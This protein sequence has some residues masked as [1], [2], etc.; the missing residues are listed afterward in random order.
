M[1]KKQFWVILIS[2]GLVLVLFIGVGLWILS[3]KKQTTNSLA[4]VQNTLAPTTTTE[5][6]STVQTPTSTETSQPSVP[7][8]NTVNPTEWIKNPETVQGLQPPPEGT[9]TSRGDVIIVYGDNTVTSKTTGAIPPVTSD[10]NSIVIQVPA[11]QGNGAVTTVTPATSATVSTGST[12]T[13]ETGETKAPVSSPSVQTSKTKA[14]AA[15]PSKTGTAGGTA[16]GTATE[17]TT[18]KTTAKASP[19]KTYTDYWVQT[20]SYSSKARAEAVKE[21][22]QARGITSIIEVKEIAGKTYYRVR[23]GPYTSQKEAQ[24]WLSLVKNLDGFS[25]SYI[26]IVQAKR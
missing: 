18:P 14:V 20:G 9:S 24:Y 12:G 19:Q 23:I 5:Q 17:P 22:L 4:S 10:P 26:S 13:G 2:V 3:I 7:T 8:D 25:E 11:P 21:Q 16:G 15:V 6:N 1:E